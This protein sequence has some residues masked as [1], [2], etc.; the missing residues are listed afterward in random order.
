MSEYVLSCSGF[1]RDSL[2]LSAKL[3]YSEEELIALIRSKDQ[4]GFTY[5]YN[6]YSK[7]LYG[8][9]ATIVPNG[10][11]AQDILQT[12]F[13]KIW[14]NFEAYDPGKGRLYTWMLNLARNA[15]IDFTR[16]TA[17]RVGS[18][19]QG[20]DHN[21]Y[22]LNKQH[23]QKADYDHIGLQSVV[24][25]LDESHRDIIQLA[26]YEG[27]TQEEIAKKLNMPL[28]TVKTRVRQAISH[29]RSKLV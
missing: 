25:N 28:G 19:I 6:N 24:N 29:L 21:V 22:E 27:Y 7:A 18:K 26:Y 13:V 9:I 12:T 14:K 20:L 3:K 10:D 23:Q 5:L 8:V 2:S 15:A 1:F 16:T 4:A 17:A 11:D